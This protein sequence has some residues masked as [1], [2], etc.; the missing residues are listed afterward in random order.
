MDIIYT[1]TPGP[2]AEKDTAWIGDGVIQNSA[3]DQISLN[4]LGKAEAI[5]K[6]TSWLETAGLG[7]ATTTYRLRDWLFSRQRYWGEPFPV[8]YDEDGVVHALPESMLP[9]DLPEVDNFSPRT[10]APDDADSSPEAPLGRAEDWIKVELDLGQGKKTYYRDT[11]VMPNWAGSCCYELRYL[12]PGEKDFLAN[13]ENERYWMGPREG[14]S[15]GG[16]D[17]YVGGVEHAVLHLLYARFWHKVLYDLGYL[18][19]LEPFH[20]LFNQGYIQAYAYTD[21]RGA[22][23]P[24]SEVQGDEASGV[25]Y[26][27]EPVNREYGKMGK[28]LKNIVTPDDICA[29]YGAD[30]FRVYE[31]SM[32]PLDM[33]RP[34]ETRAV[35]GSQRFLQR[36]WRNVVDEN[37]GEVTVS[38]DAPDLETQ[39]ALAKAIAAVTE[40]YREMRL[41]L[42]VSDL[43]VLNNHLTAL[44][45]VPRE[46]AEALVLMISPLAPHI[47]EELWNRLGHSSSLAREPFPVV[48]DE[49][50][51][52]EEEITA[53]VQINGKVKYRLQ[54]PQSISAEELEKQALETEVVQRN[55]A[56]S[57]PLK[58]IVREP[59][60]VNVVI[61][62]SK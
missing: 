31:M 22:Y 12:D 45:A 20:K 24:A 16:T 51:L 56:G 54:V 17:L 28:S 25:T 58:V 23:V 15:S 18:S 38:E 7:E 62:K 30:T 44:K 48:T 3:N 53:V 46:A 13:P 50:L 47:A 6:I 57:A 49:S 1:I 19:S 2:D 10:F 14:A 35:V 29:E 9:L 36:L 42:V 27:G 37:T 26:E 59:K 61:R 11:N 32:G 8:V 4:G 21:K 52:V 5:K 40:D 39:R 34:W 60:L 55:L 41:N 43:I 33:S